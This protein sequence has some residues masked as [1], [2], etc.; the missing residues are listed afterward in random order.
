MSL[1]N[2]LQQRNNFPRD[3]F[4]GF[5]HMESLETLTA[6]SKYNEA[7]SVSIKDA[8]KLQILSIVI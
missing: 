5:Y 3:M 2:L 8:I 6:I 4:S 1:H 7:L